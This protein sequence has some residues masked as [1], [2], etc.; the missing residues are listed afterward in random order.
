[1][2][3]TFVVSIV[4]LNVNSIFNNLNGITTKYRFLANKNPNVWKLNLLVFLRFSQFEPHFLISFFSYKKLCSETKALAFGIPG[5][6]TK[7]YTNHI[8]ESTDDTAKLYVLA[9][10]NATFQETRCKISSNIKN[11]MEDRAAANH[12]PIRLI[13]EQWGNSL[14]ALHC[15]LH[16]WI[17]FQHVAG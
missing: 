6:C 4:Y 7:D 14:N 5:G 11:T 3:Y 17:Q 1:M 13:N 8:I 16:H 15:N 10:V 9:N 2:P 12:A